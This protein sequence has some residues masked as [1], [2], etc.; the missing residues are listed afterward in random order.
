M[1]DN[2]PRNY[3]EIGPNYI[4]EINVEDYT[5]SINGYLNG[6]NINVVNT[7]DPKLWHSCLDYI[8]KQW[9]Q[10]FFEEVVCEDV[11]KGKKTTREIEGNGGKVVIKTNVASPFE[12]SNI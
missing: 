9:G 2:L 10:D 1:G 11:R 6:Q 8:C 5:A 4:L 12:S 3:V 7:R